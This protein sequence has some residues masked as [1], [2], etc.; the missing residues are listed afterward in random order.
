MFCF[1][2]L[3]SFRLK[4]KMLPRISTAFDE[5]IINGKENPQKVSAFYN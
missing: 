4:I 2:I 3:K 1:V 5:F